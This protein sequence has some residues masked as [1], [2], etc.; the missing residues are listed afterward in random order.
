MRKGNNTTTTHTYLGPETSKNFTGPGKTGCVR[1]RKQHLTTQACGQTTRLCVADIQSRLVL[2]T[3]S[4][5][6]TDLEK[7]CHGRSVR[8]CWLTR[9]IEL[10]LYE[11]RWHLGG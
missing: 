10:R 2:G 6:L 11:V 8:R 1:V 4:H 7:L 3:T 5:R 9:A